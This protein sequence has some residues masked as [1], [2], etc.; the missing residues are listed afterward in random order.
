M[1]PH[2]EGSSGT[3]STHQH[4]SEV[5]DEL[6]EARSSDEWIIESAGMEVPWKKAL[7]YDNNYR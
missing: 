1:K 7:P 4:I 6:T 5:A 3:I 2:I